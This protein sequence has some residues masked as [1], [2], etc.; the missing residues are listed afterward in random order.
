[1]NL[2]LTD[3][4]RRAVRLLDR[5]MVVNA[6]AGSGKTTVLVERFVHIL[7][8]NPTWNLN[9]VVAITFTRAAAAEMR[10]RVR[11]RLESLIAEGVQVERYQKLMEEMGSARIS[12]IHGLCSD[13]LRANAAEAHIDPAFV[14]MEDAEATLLRGKALDDLLAE[15]ELDDPESLLQLFD[16]NEAK[17][18]RDV[19]KSDKACSAAVEGY[20]DD[21]ERLL[22][23]WNEQRT[24]TWELKKNALQAQFPLF[25]VL[26]MCVSHRQET[27]SERMVL[28]LN[29]LSAHYSRVFDVDI[30]DSLQAL[31]EVSNISTQ[32]ITSKVD[33]PITDI[34]KTLKALVSDALA[35]LVSIQDTEIV[36]I[37]LWIRMCKRLRQRYSLLKQ[38]SGRLD[39][40]DLE[41]LTMR[42]MQNPDVRKRYLSE[43]EH[44][45]VDEFQDTNDAQWQIVKALAPTHEHGKLFIVGDKK[46]SIYGFRGAD[47]GV[48][49]NVQER[50]RTDKGERENLNLSQR[51]T[52]TLVDSF[53]QFFTHFFTSDDGKYAD[54]DV[55]FDAEEHMQ[56]HRQ[57]VSDDPCVQVWRF[58]ESK[59]VYI[60]RTHEAQHIADWIQDTVGSRVV[61]DKEKRTHRKAEFGDIFILF[62]SLTQ[63][64]IYEKALDAARIPFV[65]IS[66]KGYYER[67][68]IHDVRNLLAA[69]YDP[70]DNLALATVLRSPFFAFSDELLLRLRRDKGLLWTTLATPPQLSAHDEL[71]VI[72]ANRVLSD[73]ANRAQRVTV[74]DLLDDAMR[75]TGFLATLTM[76]PNGE[77]MRRNVEKFIEI[78]RNSTFTS[79]GEFT[80]YLD[81]VTTT[82]IRE[83]EAALEGEN[84]VNL[85]T[86]HA[87]KGLE[88]PIVIMANLS[89]TGGNH[90]EQVAFWKDGLA[91]K[92]ND[93][94]KETFP[95][96][97]YKRNQDLRDSAEEKRLIYVGMTRARDLVILSGSKGAQFDHICECIKAIG[98]EPAIVP[99]KSGEIRKAPP[100]PTIV[101]ND[102][103]I[104][105]ASLPSVTVADR[106]L[107]CSVT[108]LG[109]LGAMHFRAYGEQDNS[110]A[111]QNLYAS[112]GDHDLMSADTLPSIATVVRQGETH[113]TQRLIGQIVHEAIRNDTLPQSPDDTSVDDLLRA[114]AWRL[115]I[116]RED[117]L[118]DAC[119]RSRRSLQTYRRSSLY[120]D[121]ANARRVYREMPFM[122][123]VGKRT[124]HGQVDVIAQLADGTWMIVDYKTSYLPS[125]NREAFA[126]NHVRQYYFQLG[127]YAEAARQ[128]LG[129]VPTT[130][131]YYVQL[132][133]LMTVAEHEWRTEFDQL[134]Q[135]IQQLVGNRY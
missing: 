112:L 38:Q 122:L 22:A 37:S 19:L 32:Y 103:P 83:G 118:E 55:R 111:R 113:V 5:N 128:Q 95:Y 1:M 94:D 58:Q 2:Q 36:F 92:K 88:A 41:T 64:R 45:L 63:V 40:E 39:F 61:Y 121:I 51:S 98:V 115:G 14:V 53:N 127:A 24:A 131:I 69:L 133:M 10:N 73:L 52:S 71:Q 59:Y 80:A 16:V 90:K 109:Y 66:G 126:Q 130:A 20:E 28:Q 89:V 57:A 62:R 12:T 135:R 85:M 68:E 13:L 134:E 46:Q 74:G 119:Q 7:G 56:A 120:Q 81:E 11:G 76:L 30:N 9:K 87:S 29:I 26:E 91:V 117:E 79:L 123:R 72:R 102:K 114:Y 96:L 82:E 132:N 35:N 78:A 54:F 86:I 108:Q 44:L 129:I 65:T 125:E 3:N 67:Q 48:F 27:K 4:Q 100:K 84:A 49:A 93:A 124:L 60:N 25:A 18:I 110:A 15:L 106:L 70:S 105:L 21:E 101:H 107:Q 104:L 116:T 43:I 8:E 77:R 50:I 34:L 6:G 23:H 42:L 47:V 31:Y 99:R 17:N 97:W 33:K 75:L